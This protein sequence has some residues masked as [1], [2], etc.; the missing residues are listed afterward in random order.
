MENIDLVIFDFFKTIA[1]PIK[2][3]ECGIKKFIN[4]VYELLV[5]QK[6]KDDI[7]VDYIRNAFY[8]TIGF[9]EKM[10]EISL[11]EVPVD[12]LIKTFTSRLGIFDQ[13]ETHKILK[14]YTDRLAEINE[15]Y[16]DAREILKYLKNRGYK[17]CLLSNVQQYHYIDKVLGDSGVKNLFDMIFYSSDIGIRKPHPHIFDYVLDRMDTSSENALMVGDNFVADFYGAIMAGLHA[18]LIVRKKEE[19][20]RLSIYI[21]KGKIIRNLLELKKFL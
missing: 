2:P 9:Y 17:I 10:R 4:D 16:D 6:R 15:I 1:R 5:E 19:F 21:R 11:F 14:M 3:E 7:S 12:V 8:D 18:I 20:S 13:G